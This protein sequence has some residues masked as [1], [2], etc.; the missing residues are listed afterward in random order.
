MSTQ[1]T[2]NSIFK[3]NSREEVCENIASFFYNNAI[4]FNVARTEEFAKMFESVAKHGPGFKP[5]SYHEIRVKYLR[6]KYDST[7]QD[8]EEH[9]SYWKKFGCSIMTDGWTD[10]RRRTIINF[11]VNSPKGTIFLKSINASDISK[12]ANKIF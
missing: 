8:I 7:M 4:P 5:P 12:T 10:K 9:K 6:K 3:K 1:A 2:I 11:L